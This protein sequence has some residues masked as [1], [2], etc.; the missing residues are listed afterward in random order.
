MLC[1]NLIE[2]TVQIATSQKL[3]V[4]VDKFYQQQVHQNQGSL[5]NL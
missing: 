1:D 2:T 5:E 4:A 3:F